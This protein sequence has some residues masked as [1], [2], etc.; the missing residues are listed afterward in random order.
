RRAAWAR[1]ASSLRFGRQP[2]PSR[3]PSSPQTPWPSSSS[4]WALLWD[5]LSLSVNGCGRARV[6]RLTYHDPVLRFSFTGGTTD[7]GFRGQDTDKMCAGAASITA[8]SCAVDDTLAPPPF[9]VRIQRPRVGR[10]AI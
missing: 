7:E 2:S 5:R 10:R 4:T 9:R 8:G 1:G 6:P 3:L